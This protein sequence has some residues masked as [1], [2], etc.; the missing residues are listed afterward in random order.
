MT[1]Q[2][3]DFEIPGMFEQEST[4]PKM[5]Y[6]SLSQELRDTIEGKK[7]IDD[8]ITLPDIPKFDFKTDRSGMTQEEISEVTTELNSIR[9]AYFGVEEQVI[10]VKKDSSVSN[11]VSKVK[12]LFGGVEE[13]VIPSQE[14]LK[15][16]AERVYAKLTERFNAAVEMHKQGGKSLAKRLERNSELKE[17]YNQEARKFFEA[18]DG[19]DAI[20]IYLNELSLLDTDKMDPKQVHKI[21]LLAK[22]LMERRQDYESSLAVFSQKM[23]SLDEYIKIT[24]EKCDQIAMSL[25]HQRTLIADYQIRLKNLKLEKQLVGY[26]IDSSSVIPTLNEGMG[27]MVRLEDQFNDILH[28]LTRLNVEAINS[29]PEYSRHNKVTYERLKKQ[30]DELSKAIKKR[31]GDSLDDALRNYKLDK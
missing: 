6:G 15:Q 3:M 26:D 20:N 10:R 19:Y 16:D 4:T 7:T 23:N 12:K 18:K 25:N 29:M 8:Y 1:E 21:S 9:E 13:K 5:N 30:N 31:W 28:D 17:A 11:L 2:Q 14:G 24:G 27:E 22:S